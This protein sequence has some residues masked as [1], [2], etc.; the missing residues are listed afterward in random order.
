MTRIQLSAP[1]LSNEELPLVQEAFD[2]NWIAPLGP[3]VD[4]FEEE[5]ARVVDAGYACALSSGTAGLHLALLMLGVGAGDEVIVPT[6]TFVASANPVSYVGARP[7]FIDCDRESWNLDPG[8]LAEELQRRAR[9]NQLPKAVI[10]VDLYGQ[11]ADYD[12]ITEVCANYG[13]PL[14]EDAAEALGATYRG[15][16]AG[17]FGTM[18]VLSFNGNKII[19]SGGGGMLVSNDRKWTDRA[20]FL[21]TQARD[22]APHYQHSTIGYNY[23]LSNLQAAVGRGQLRV[24]PER[25]DA[26]RANFAFYE[27]ELSGTPGISFMPEASYGRATRW[28]TCVQVDP[29]A[30]GATR[31]DLRRAFERDN[32]E[33]RPVWKPMHLQP[34]Y[35]GCPVVGGSVAQHIF[36][37]G[38]CLPSG[39]GLTE[40]ELER[41]AHI[42]KTVRERP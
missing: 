31:E 6:L 25:V 36:E 38:L 1:H 41:V 23:R 27:R 14:V 10:S 32:I 22:A 37:H 21:A 15:K 40:S 33:A 4:A 2:T 8:L 19:T 42:F 16:P 3:H 30:F 11:A 9:N 20:R 5:L 17:G 34:V 13:I 18:A 26:R 39:S 7:I 24:L 29:Q 35:A 12:L 28:L